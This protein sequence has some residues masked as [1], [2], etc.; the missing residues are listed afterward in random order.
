M[1]V[2]TLNRQIIQPPARGCYTGAFLAEGTPSIAQV[3]DFQSK[4]GKAPAI[5]MW[6]HAFT[7]GFDFPREACETMRSLG[8]IP[9]I[10]LEPWSWRGQGD[11][12]FSLRRILAGEFDE[13]LRNL[14]VGARDFAQPVFLAF[15]HEMNA[16]LEN[17]WYPWAGVPEDY[18]AAFQHV[19]GI[20][21]EAGAANANWVYNVNEWDPNLI[22]AFYPGDDF[23]DWLAVDGFNFG[24]TQ[25]WSTWKSFDEI[26][27]AAYHQL[28]RLSS[29]PIMIGEMAST[30]EGGSK[31]RWIAQAF[32][33]LKGYPQIKALI[34]FNINKE[35]DW[36]IDS[37]P[38]SLR[39]FQ[40]AMGDPYLVGT[41]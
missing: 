4:A 22:G 33:A 24:T 40:R 28:T 20:F 10:K 2:A 16:P 27:R 14:A 1:R 32:R 30:E 18:K 41:A 17:R 34:W 37:S 3:R 36:R 8:S 15:G 6:F 29:K 23:I 39:A 11:A 13:G 12:S 5:T 19:W 7:L 38:K 9:F 21:T 25:D 26:F 35:T 31:K